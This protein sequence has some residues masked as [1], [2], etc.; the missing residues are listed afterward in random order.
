MTFIAVEPFDI[1]VDSVDL[2]YQAGDTFEAPEHWERNV[3]YEEQLKVD[4]P[5]FGVR[6]VFTVHHPLS[7]ESKII[8]PL[9]ELEGE[10]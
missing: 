10:Q 3:A 8:L 4:Y 7:G 2:Q 6:V 9:R 1:T 5:E